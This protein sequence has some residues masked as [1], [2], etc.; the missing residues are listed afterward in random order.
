MTTTATATVAE[1]KVRRRLRRRPPASIRNGRALLVS[2][3]GYGFMVLF[4]A[5]LG[6][7]IGVKGVSGVVPL[8]AV[9]TVSI[10]L[11]CIAISRLT[12]TRQLWSLALAVAWGG[13]LSVVLGYLIATMGERQSDADTAFFLQLFLTSPFVLAVASVWHFLRG[14]RWF[15]GEHE[16][17][18][19]PEESGARPITDPLTVVPDTAPA[20]HVEIAIPV[21]IAAAPDGPIGTTVSVLAP[22]PTAAVPATVAPLLTVQGLKKH[23]PIYG[24]IMRKQIGT[25]YAVDGVD[26]EIMPGET[27]ALVGESGCGKT[28]LGRTIIQLTQPTAG[29]VVFDGYEFEDVD[30]EDMRPLRRRMQIIFQDPFGSLNPR[31]P[32]SDIIGEGLLAQ[33]M[34]DRTARDKRVEDALELVGLRREYTRRYPHEFSG[35]Q[36]QRIGVARALALG[37]DFIVAD[38]PVSA[39]DVS[40]Q[41]QVLNLLLDLKRDLKLTYL[42]ISH[43]LSV[44]QY[45]SDRVG[46]MYLGKLVEVG[47]VEQLYANPRHPYTVALLSAIPSPDPRQRKKRLVLTGDV[48]SP[49]APPSGCRFHTRC[50]LRERL[51]NP[52][53]CV[54]RGAAAPRVRRAGPPGVV[55][56]RRGHQPGHRG[57]GGR[58]G[59]GRRCG[60][61]RGRVISRPQASVLLGA[62][63]RGR[64]PAPRRRPGR[65]MRSGPVRAVSPSAVTPSVAPSA[66]HG[67][68]DPRSR[69]PRP[70]PGPWS[71][72]SSSSARRISRS[73]RRGP[74]SEPPRPTRTSRRCG[75][76]R[77]VW[78]RCWKRLQT[79]VPRI[80]DYPETAAAAKAYE[81][82]FPGHARRRDAPPRLDHRR[83]QRRGGRGQPAAVGGSREVRRGPPPD[84]SAVQR[85]DPDAA[86]PGQVGARAVSAPP[87]AVARAAER[88]AVSA[89]LRAPARRTARPRPRRPRPGTPPA[90]RCRRPPAPGSTRPRRRRPPGRRR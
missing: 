9:V 15:N 76:Q 53:N 39:L 78:R 27:F 40:I 43:N 22:A 33:G 74:T 32:V 23:F 48:P 66:R 36:R 87:R 29:R 7:F 45:F 17:R 65:G 63:P 21:T 69:R 10:G 19:R 24:G 86:V 88:A 71:R 49:A 16:H 30:P 54:T 58:G 6:M 56:S 11:V 83:R 90:T 73:R 51:G 62:S 2:V 3:A 44:V 57:P 64:G 4:V 35:G 37:P 61:R 85:G 52:E 89:S 50:W 67:R 28:T 25:V 80:A 70:G 8:I 38:E 34:T 41:S 77:T 82:A 68:G 60:G 42:F 81:A 26:F 18:L 20:A 84:R 72:P 1:P 13:L 79:Q 55:P 59:A 14:A 12:K 5:I 47:S 46:V 31:M 75:A